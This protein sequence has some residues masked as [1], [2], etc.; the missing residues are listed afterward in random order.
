MVSDLLILYRDGDKK[1][2][3]NVV[4]YGYRQTNQLQYFFEKNGYRSFIPADV[5]KFFGRLFDYEEE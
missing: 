4:N 5:V 1:I 3:H 2:I